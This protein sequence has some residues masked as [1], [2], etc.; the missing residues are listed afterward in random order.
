MLRSVGRLDAD[1]IENRADGQIAIAQ[2]L[3]D[4]DSGG[5]RQSLEHI[6]LEPAKLLLGPGFRTCALNQLSRHT[7]TIFEISKSILV[8][9]GPDDRRGTL[10][11][12][13]RPQYA[14]TPMLQRAA[15]HTV[16]CPPGGSVVEGH[17]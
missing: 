6:G 12:S 1:S 9:L 14:S 5:M 4:A 15:R 16:G 8:K 13:Q 2:A 7:H 17:R 10:E 11:H 3:D